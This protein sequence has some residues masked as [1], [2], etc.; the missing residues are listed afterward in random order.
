MLN[1]TYTVLAAGVHELKETSFAARHDGLGEGLTSPLSRLQLGTMTPSA[2]G[3]LDDD[4]E[5]TLERMASPRSVMSDEVLCHQCPDQ[6]KCAVKLGA[7]NSLHL[8]VGQSL[9][10]Q[11][12]DATAKDLLGTT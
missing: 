12:A 2:S 11:R 6:T 1:S 10:M 4:D 7:Q 5:A 3:T 9:A 8:S